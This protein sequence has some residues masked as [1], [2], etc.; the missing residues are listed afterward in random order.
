M[1]RIRTTRISYR[2]GHKRWR[3]CTGYL[4]HPCGLRA[5]RGSAGGRIGHGGV[6]ARRIPVAGGCHDRRA[7]QASALLS[8]PIP[9]CCPDAGR[10]QALQ[11]HLRGGT[12]P[13]AAGTGGA[14]PCDPVVCPGPGAGGRHAAPHL[15][16]AGAAARLPGGTLVMDDGDAGERFA[17]GCWGKH[18]VSAGATSRITR[19]SFAEPLCALRTRSPHP[20]GAT[21]ALP[22]VP[23]SPRRRRPPRRTTVGT[24]RACPACPRSPRRR[25]P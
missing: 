25:W 5:C 19:L 11:R 7:A 24:G 8:A 4:G 15:Q 14:R 17:G 2:R 3:G 9:R 23:P 1:R 16:P 10:A 6:M 12:P 18:A 13:M 22:T 20:P 21:A